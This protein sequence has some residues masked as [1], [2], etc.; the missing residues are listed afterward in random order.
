M[1][2][3]NYLYK[4]NRFAT[5]KFVFK[6]HTTEMFWVVSLEKT[7]HSRFLSGNQGIGQGKV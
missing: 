1:R 7:I 2:Q 4:C 5:L 3:H 6:M